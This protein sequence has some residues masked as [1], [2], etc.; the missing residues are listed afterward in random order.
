MLNGY[1]NTFHQNFDKKWPNLTS[2]IN[3]KD[4]DNVQFISPNKSI[5]WD[6]L[7]SN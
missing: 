1:K 5:I 4:N 7:H 3:K 2:E 6:K